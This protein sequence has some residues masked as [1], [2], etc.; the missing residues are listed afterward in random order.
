[1]EKNTQLS[2]LT[3]PKFKVEVSK[4]PV[5]AEHFSPEENGAE[6]EIVSQRRYFEI[7]R[8]K[9][10]DFKMSNISYAITSN[11]IH[12]IDVH[13]E[14]LII[15]SPKSLGYKKLKKGNTG[16]WKTVANARY[17]SEPE[18]FRRIV[19]RNRGDIDALNNQDFHESY[20]GKSY[21][22]VDKT[23]PDNWV[24][25]QLIKK[26]NIKELV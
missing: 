6:Y 4:N 5:H 15:L 19:L 25:V 26:T 16:N 12:S 11:R 17:K 10:P 23:R 3:L 14:K 22:L 24:V 18:P 1:M 13:G 21:I 20:S 2:L 8:E 9:I 7:M